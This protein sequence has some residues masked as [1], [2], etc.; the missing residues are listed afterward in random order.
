[1]SID[2]LIPDANQI[3]RLEPGELA[4]YLIMD[5]KTQTKSFYLGNYVRALERIYP[6]FQPISDVREALMESFAWLVSEALIYPDFD[7]NSGWY[8][9]SKRTEHFSTPASINEIA[10]AR[11]RLPKAF[12]HPIIVQHAAPIFYSGKYD[13][14][15]FEAFKQIEIVVRTATKLPKSLVGD[16]LMRA[17]FRPA[18][19]DKNVSAGLLVDANAVES[20][21]LALA[22]LMAGAFGI[23]RNPAGHQNMEVNARESAELLIFA[24]HLMG[25]V[26]KRVDSM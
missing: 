19:P 6:N 15:V 25:I 21:Q 11:E 14:A 18:N 1:M 17:A 16:Q 22:N 8:K 10:S 12:L 26:D 13:T 3:L 23:F 9:L 5:L 2:Q 20:E 24:S 4:G 7:Q